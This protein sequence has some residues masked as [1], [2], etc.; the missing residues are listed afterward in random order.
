MEY[1][2]GNGSYCR[3]PHLIHE[4]RSPLV[5]SVIVRKVAAAKGEEETGGCSLDF[6]APMRTGDDREGFSWLILRE[7]INGDG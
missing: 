5:G 4:E 6:L 7:E 2:R 3:Q 1:S